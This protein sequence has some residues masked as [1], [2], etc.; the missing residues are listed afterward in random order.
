MEASAGDSTGRWIVPP[1]DPRL[2]GVPVVAVRW[3]PDGRA[4]W[5]RTMDAIGAASFWSVPVD[6][7]A[8]RRVARTGDSRRS[9]IRSEFSTDGRRIYLS[10]LERESDVWTLELR[11]R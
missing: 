8:P 6:G 5:V 2:G 4:L 10:L 9:A 1:R 11:G 7:G 3:T